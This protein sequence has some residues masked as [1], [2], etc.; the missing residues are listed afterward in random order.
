MTIKQ[1]F[2]KENKEEN[3]YFLVKE[4]KEESNYF[5]VFPYLKNKEIFL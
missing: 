4:N 1:L 2:L 5:L 3:N